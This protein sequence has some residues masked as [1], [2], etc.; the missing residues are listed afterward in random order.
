M[1]RFLFCIKATLP[2]TFPA[3]SLEQG[4]MSLVK[5][6][7]ENCR[8]FFTKISHFGKSET[9]TR[10]SPYS[11]SATTTTH[12][13]HPVEHIRFAFLSRKEGMQISDTFGQEF[14]SQECKIG[15]EWLPI[16]FGHLHFKIR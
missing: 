3:L 9:V 8:A 2:E 1:S 14:P 10:Q 7:F 16:L 6:N 11:A 15:F 12:I 13:Y 5:S 4:P